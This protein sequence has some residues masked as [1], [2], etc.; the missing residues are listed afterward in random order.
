M[1]EGQVR[2]LSRVFQSESLNFF[3]YR[4]EQLE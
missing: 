4:S 3:L 2:D 1:I